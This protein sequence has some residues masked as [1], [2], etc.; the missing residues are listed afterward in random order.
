[1]GL[2]SL[3]RD[4]VRTYVNGDVESEERGVG[5]RVL[6]RH[7]D[8]G[9]LQELVQVLVGDPCRRKSSSESFIHLKRAYHSSR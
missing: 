1:M 8:V 5:Q 3:I 2:C 7:R 4:S 6:L 9:V